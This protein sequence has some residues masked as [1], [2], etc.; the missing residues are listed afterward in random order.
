MVYF[1]I[2]GLGYNC[3]YI[4]SKCP[5]EK[6]SCIECIKDRLR[7]LGFE[8]DSTIEIFK[9]DSI[10]KQLELERDTIWQKFLDV[11][12]IK[13]ILIMDKESG[14]TVINYTVSGVDV[15]VEL[16]SGFIQAN[17]TFSESGE[18]IFKTLK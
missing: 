8:F 1:K 6:T 16:L 15:D 13:H 17:I 4:E 7:D 2:N 18:A 9:L 11:L 14:L 12:N 10:E 5:K 3:G